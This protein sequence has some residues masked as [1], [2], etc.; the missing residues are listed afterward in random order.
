M[1]GSEA[2]TAVALY[3]NT[4]KTEIFGNG[5][6]SIFKF[7][8]MEKYDGTYIVVNCLPFYYKNVM[9]TDTINI[10]VHVKVLS[11]GEPDLKRLEAVKN[12]IIALFELEDGVELDGAHF[13]KKTSSDTPVLDED[14]TY[15]VNIQI[16][17]HHSNVRY[18]KISN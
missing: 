13:E 2:V 8:K 18:K 12:A 15:Y 1:T 6:G 17:C 3:L 9:N 10:N 7:K 4:N 14:G 11:S 16:D 5:G